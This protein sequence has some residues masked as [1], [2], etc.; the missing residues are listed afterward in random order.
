MSQNSLPINS[1]VGAILGDLTNEEKGSRK[2]GLVYKY[3]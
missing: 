3:Q 2:F 1:F